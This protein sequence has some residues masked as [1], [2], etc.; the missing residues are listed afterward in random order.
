[1]TS[2]SVYYDFTLIIPLSSEI[3]RKL[4]PSNATAPVTH[5]KLTSLPHTII[6]DID[7]LVSGTLI[8][9]KEDQR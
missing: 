5:M 2:F 9:M 8:G 4:T 6:T 1:M 3:Q 7:E